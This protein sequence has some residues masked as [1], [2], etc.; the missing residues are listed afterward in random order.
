MTRHG[1]RTRASLR[2]LI[3]Y[4]LITGL[5][6]LDASLVDTHAQQMPDVS[7]R[8]PFI[9]GENA[10]EEAKKRIPSVPGKEQRSFKE[11]KE[12]LERERASQRLC[13]E[14]YPSP[15]SGANSRR[16]HHERVE[17]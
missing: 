10:E 3:F 12:C 1:G 4:A 14:P 6:V 11:I 9:A 13:D 8:R 5:S 15:Q 16:P 2:P 7:G 17:Q